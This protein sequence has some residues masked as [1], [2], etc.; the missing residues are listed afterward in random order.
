MSNLYGW[1]KNDL[2]T[3]FTNPSEGKRPTTH[4]VKVIRIKKTSISGGLQAVYPPPI[5]FVFFRSL[6]VGVLQPVKPG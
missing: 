2:S 5:L 3:N 4:E 6:E 1:V